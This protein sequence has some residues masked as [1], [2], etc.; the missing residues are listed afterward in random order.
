MAA[1]NLP[2]NTQP[3][4][5]ERQE[6]ESAQAFQGFA[7]YRDMGAERSLAKVAQKLGKSKALM[8]RWSVRWQ[9]VVRSDAWDDELDRQTRV[10]LK[11]GVTGMRKNHVNI[12][13]AMLVKALQALQRIPADEMTPKDVS[14]M[15]DV[16]AKLER[17]SRGEATERT[18]GKQTIA[19]E[20]HTESVNLSGLSDDE[21]DRLYE[22]ASKLAA[23]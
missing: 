4:L 21:L 10:E 8:E 3:E 6:G 7:A 12:A 23:E 5:W 9:W 22:I 15:V 18:E 11:E 20:I 17:I 13:K 16:A 2:Q 14:T 1:K 19:G